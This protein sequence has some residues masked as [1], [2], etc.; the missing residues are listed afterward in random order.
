MKNKNRWNNLLGLAS[1]LVLIA[2]TFYA[3]SDISEGSVRDVFQ[4]AASKPNESSELNTTTTSSEEKA[5]PGDMPSVS[6]ADWDLVLVGPKNKIKQEISEDQ[7]EKVEDDSDEKIARRIYDHYHQLASA[8]EKAGYPLVIVS[9]FRSVAYQQQVF[10]SSVE[11]NMSKENLSKEQAVALTKQ[12]VT[13]PG[14][15]EHHTGLAVDVVD[16]YWYN[17]YQNQAG[18]V[19]DAAYGS[20]AGAK[21]LANNAFQYGFIIRYPEGKEGITGITYEPWH[22]RYVG[23]ASAKYITDHKITLEEYL[24]LLD[25][26]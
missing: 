20:Q 4:T 18:E 21:W 23:L 11:R 3:L 15:S 6:P 16:E 2:T 25:K 1:V 24:E 19:L 17:N 12:T 26:K 13:E 10:D 5:S 7:L 22:L 8:S 9:A 14:Y